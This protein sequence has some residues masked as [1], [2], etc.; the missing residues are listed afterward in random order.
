MRKRTAWS[1]VSRS[2]WAKVGRTA[3]PSE[4]RRPTDPGERRRAECERGTGN[5]IRRD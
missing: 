4:R 3:E 5:E 2:T 1:K